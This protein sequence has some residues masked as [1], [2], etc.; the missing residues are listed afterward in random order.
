MGFVAPSIFKVL[1]NKIALV[2]MQMIGR[3]KERSLLMILF[4]EFLGQCLNAKILLQYW[5]S[6][7]YITKISKIKVFST[8]YFFPYFK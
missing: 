6:L 5:S 8:K 1:K 7:V 3:S 4:E 2:F